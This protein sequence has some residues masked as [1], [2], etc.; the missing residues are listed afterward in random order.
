M[1]LYEYQ[2]KQLFAR[3]GIPVSDGI[4]ATTVGEAR[5]ASEQI[6]SA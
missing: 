6:G 4:L 5:T 3:Y 1:D 2:G